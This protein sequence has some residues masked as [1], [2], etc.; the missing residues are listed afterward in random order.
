VSIIA[1][2]F[3]LEADAPLVPADAPTDEF[4][5]EQVPSDGE[6]LTRAVVALAQHPQKMFRAVTNLVPGV[7]RAVRRARD[8]SLP[9]ELP[10]PLERVGAV[11][12]SMSAAKGVQEEVGNTTLEDWA[13]LAA[14]ALFT[15]AMRAY[16]RLRIGERLRPAINLIAS[17]VPG[18]PWP[19]YLAGAQLVALHPLGPILDDAGLNLTVISYLDHIDFGFIGCR[20]LTPDIDDIGAAVPGALQDLMKAA[21][22]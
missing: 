20:E 16:T 4:E 22:L 14:P 13:E 9:V 7:V 11:S 6:M 12:E 10:D 2:L 1:A 21:G 18:P 3:D 19:L 5:P 8:E 17:N 15:R